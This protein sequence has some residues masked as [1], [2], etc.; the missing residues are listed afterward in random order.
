MVWR[1]MMGGVYGYEDEYMYDWM[2]GGERG[3]KI[4]SITNQRVCYKPKET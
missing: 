2:S 3:D 1:G 4:C